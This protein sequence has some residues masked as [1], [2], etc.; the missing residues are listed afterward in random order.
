MSRLAHKVALVTGAGSGIGRGIATAFARE[1]A[2]VVVNDRESSEA[3]SA[4]CREI[5]KMGA[6]AVS[7][8]ADVSSSE[9]VAAM[10]QEIGDRFGRLDIL[11]NNAGIEFPAPIHEMTEEQWDAVMDT[12]LKGAFRCLR[13]ACD[14]M[15][16]RRQGCIINISSIHDTLPKYH[17][18][19]YSCAKAGLLMLTKAAALELAEFGIRVN[20]ISPGPILTN[21]NR[22]G[23][24]KLSETFL[25]HMVPLGG[26]FGSPADIAPAAV[27]LASDE[28]KFVTGTT[29]Y[30][31]AGHRDSLT[32][33]LRIHLDLLTDE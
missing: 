31:D 24:S 21:M 18:A 10:F 22:E 13:A 27:Y 5:E 26:A 17:F 29:L 2:A 25:K 8:C 16:P 3:T 20:T 32:R 7:I 4:V 23:A 1:G 12:N 11:V 14:L 15:I 33:L 30:I 28:A 6:E 19:H 9:Q